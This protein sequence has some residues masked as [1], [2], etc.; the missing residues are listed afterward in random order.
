MWRADL[1]FDALYRGR[2]RDDPDASRETK[3][4]KSESDV[5]L[6][7]YQDE[8]NVV[9]FIRFT[10]TQKPPESLS[11]PSKSDVSKDC[12]KLEQ[13]FKTSALS[14]TTSWK[15]FFNVVCNECTV[16]CLF[17]KKEEYIFAFGYEKMEGL[18]PQDFKHQNLHACFLQKVFYAS[19][20]KIDIMK[21]ID[22]HIVACGVCCFDCSTDN[23]TLFLDDLSGNYK[24]TY[25]HIKFAADIMNNNINGFTTVALSNRDSWLDWYKSIQKFE[26]SHFDFTKV[27]DRF[28]YIV[29]IHGN[30]KDV[31]GK[32]DVD[33]LTLKPLDQDLEDQIYYKLVPI[34]KLSEGLK[35]NE[36]PDPPDYNYGQ[37]ILFL[38]KDVTIHP[39]KPVTT[40]TVLDRTNLSQQ[41]QQ[42]QHLTIYMIQLD[43]GFHKYVLNIESE[44]DNIW[45]L[46]KPMLQGYR[47]CLH[48]IAYVPSNEIFNREEHKF[49]K[50]YEHTENVFLLNIP[51]LG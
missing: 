42:Q 46:F 7:L 36:I 5:I 17:Y 27:R 33:N 12:S 35:Y 40:T 50:Q 43:G 23:I 20:E 4:P 38:L 29:D 51:N 13:V 34:K 28:F 9:S 19:D 1:L 10:S 14:S 6:E 21:K 26:K 47:K 37:R 15:L 16:F 39:N 22:L 3:K 32:L 45:D 31:Y 48:H 11:L 24:P 49:V 8:S 25:K 2:T 18:H 30:I 41:Q 44:D